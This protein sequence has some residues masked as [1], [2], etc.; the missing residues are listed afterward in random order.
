MSGRVLSY[1][2]AGIPRQMPMRFAAI[3]LS[4]VALGGCAGLGL[5]FGGPMGGQLASNA[6]APQP[7]LAS[8]TITSQ[9]DPSDWETIR[10]TIEGAP[11]G[12]SHLEW[13]NA[14]TGSIGTIA[15]AADDGEACRAFATT[16]NDV[17]GIRRYRGNACVLPNGR[18]QLRAVTADDA[19]LT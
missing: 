15:V 4:T 2:G 12:G 19:T 8:A 9:A 10:R 11:Q 13:S 16:I 7:I 17:R 14:I 6:A 18:A 3:L 5:P 1:I